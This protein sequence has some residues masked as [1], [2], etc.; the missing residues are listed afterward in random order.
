MNP[1]DAT[2]TA[3]DA[4]PGRKWPKIPHSTL[5]AGWADSAAC[6]GH[7]DEDWIPSLPNGKKPQPQHYRLARTFCRRCPIQ[8][9]CK[10]FG[11]ETSSE[12]IWGGWYLGR[13]K[14]Q[15]INLLSQK[16]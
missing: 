10:R 3:Q 8:R 2:E 1:V 5:R 12:G 9:D 6:K 15:H 16:P 13:Y 7:I 4:R 14:G 11:L